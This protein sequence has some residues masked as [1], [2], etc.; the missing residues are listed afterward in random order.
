MN[1]HR[2]R[3]RDRFARH[4]AKLIAA[5]NI[6]E[7][8]PRGARRFFLGATRGVGTQLGM[9]SRYCVLRS[10]ADL[11]GDNVS[12][13]SGVYLLAPEH[14]TI[15]ANVSIH[16]MCYLDATGGI[17]IGDDVSIAHGVTIMSTT[18]ETSDIGVPIKDQGIDRRRT[19]IEDN[20]WIGAKATV[21]AGITIHSG[22]IV[23][24]GAVV[25]RDVPSYAIV[26]GVPARKLRTRGS[27]TES[28][29]ANG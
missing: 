8:T 11:C 24:A 18:H 29:V 15:G 22:A 7:Y 6:L 12:I 13:G 1:T 3:G 5:T 28:V 4:R 16:P 23:A 27:T 17:K 9:V 2:P 19:V 21:L 20:V 25:T 14:L 10:I 26:A